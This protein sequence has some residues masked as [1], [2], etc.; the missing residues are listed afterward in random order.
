MAN[1]F[2]I[3]GRLY[4]RAVSSGPVSATMKATKKYFLTEMKLTD[5]RLRAAFLKRKLKAHLTLL[6]RTV[7]R[8]TRNGID[9]L[10]HPQVQ[11]IFRVLGEI[12]YEIAA[13]EGELQRRRAEERAKYE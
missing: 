4:G 7:F 6:G 10:N 5:I 12:E 8:L 1:I 11:T 9:P 2:R 3:A 13:T